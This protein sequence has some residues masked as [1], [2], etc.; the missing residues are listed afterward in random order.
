[1][2]LNVN[3][4][5][6]A[7]PATADIESAL[8]ATS[9]SEDWFITLDDGDASLDAVAQADG[10]F[11]VA[12]VSGATRRMAKADAATVK[13][14]F[15]RYLAGDKDWSQAV[16]WNAPPRPA[17]RPTFVKDTR[18]LIGRA[19]DG[20]PPWAIVAMIAVIG[21]VWLMFEWPD[22]AYM[23]F[24]FAH[25]DWF[26]IGLIALPM[27]MLLVLAAASK[28][29]DL[30]RAAS[31]HK[32]TGRVTASKIAQRSIKFQNEPERIENYAAVT[33]E[34][35]APNG[36]KVV[37]SRIGIGDDNRG[38]DAAPTVK[39][40]PV[41]ANVTVYYD[42]DDPRN[43]VLE[44]GGPKGI[45]AK[46]C[47][48]A[49]VELAIAGGVIWWLIARAPGFVR[50]EF[51]KANESLVV[52]TFGI[53]TLLAMMCYAHWRMSKKAMG[54]PAVAGKIMRSE[55]E[56]YKERVSANGT[57]TAF[58]RPV[59]EYA[60]EVGGQEYRSSQ[61]RLNATMAGAQRWAEGVTRKYPEG[62]DVNVR[63][64]PDNPA[65]AILENPGSISW[66]LM[67]LAVAAFAFSAWQTGAFG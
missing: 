31:W 6:V 35:T 48:M 42:P 5:L 2:E 56:S 41:G 3:D 30:R 44:R 29:L 52:L 62:G 59:I 53:G 15:V 57:L 16:R 27:V 60:Y 61:I 67:A 36:R 23:L 25:S 7:K 18:P 28:G 55:V 8:A 46:G 37:G 10:S 65:N 49:L 33:Y 19:S 13:T 51:P 54:W 32:T 26:W 24:P 4:R 22:L 11:T 50:A 1:M 43:C 38:A 20:P 66:Y 12:Y 17:K 47:V 45:E 21:F 64:D 63:H 40:Y 34:F 14:A 39:R 58:Y 9:F